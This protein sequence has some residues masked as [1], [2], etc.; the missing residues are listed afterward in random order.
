MLWSPM[1][2]PTTAMVIVT[3][4]SVTSLVDAQLNGQPMTVTISSSLRA[5][6]LLP[7]DVTAMFG[8]VKG[9][10]QMCVSLLA[11]F[12]L[13]SDWTRVGSAADKELPHC[14]CSGLARNRRELPAPPTE[15]VE[16]FRRCA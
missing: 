12:H 10:Q 16:K 1:S 4:P 7:T 3:H 14:S 8:L 13:N 6:V 2:S 15:G 9:S 11:L 5:N